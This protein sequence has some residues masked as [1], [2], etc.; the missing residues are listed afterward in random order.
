MCVAV[1]QGNA[2]ADLPGGDVALKLAQE[3]IGDN[4]LLAHFGR[5]VQ[6]VRFGLLDLMQVVYLTSNHFAVNLL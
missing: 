3:G 1:E 4:A 6:V 5:F 2:I